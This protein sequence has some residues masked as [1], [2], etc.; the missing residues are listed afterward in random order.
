MTAKNDDYSIIGHLLGWLMITSSPKMQNKK[1]QGRVHSFMGFPSHTGDVGHSGFLNALPRIYPRR[2]LKYRISP[3][4]GRFLW[5]PKGFIP[6][7]LL[8]E[9]H[10]VH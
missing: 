3:C 9:Y 1:K 6:L 4:F 7:L 2:L 8:Y 10:S 5:V